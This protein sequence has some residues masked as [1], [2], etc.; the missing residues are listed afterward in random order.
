MVCLCK[1]H[2][3]FEKSKYNPHMK[4]EKLVQHLFATSPSLFALVVEKNKN[5]I[6][7]ATYMKQFSTW[8]AENYIY[9]DCLFLDERSRGL[10]IG[11]KI[12]QRIQEERQKLDCSLMQWQTPKFN[13]RAIKFYHTIGATKKSKERFFLNI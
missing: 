6:G 11:K 13:K 10:G 1:L 5:L 3:S 2:A 4:E 12:M 7:Y 8:D 9:L